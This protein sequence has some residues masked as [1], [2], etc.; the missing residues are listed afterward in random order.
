MAGWLSPSANAMSKN[1]RCTRMRTPKNRSSK[2]MKSSRASHADEIEAPSSE[3]ARENAL[4]V[5]Y[6]NRGPRA[7]EAGSPG[8]RDARNRNAIHAEAR[9]GRPRSVVARGF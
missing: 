8:P 7:V 9:R 4:L 1:Q 2:L 5:Q 3:Q 6:H